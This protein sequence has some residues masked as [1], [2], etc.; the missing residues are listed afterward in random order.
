MCTCTIFTALKLWICCI[1][2]ICR[3]C[4]K[5]HIICLFCMFT[6]FVS[7]CW[8]LIANSS[9]CAQERVLLF[10]CKFILIYFN[11]FLKVFMFSTSHKNWKMYNW[12]KITTLVEV[13]YHDDELVKYAHSNNVTVSYI[14]IIFNFTTFFFVYRCWVYQKVCPTFLLLRCYWY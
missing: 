2:K 10:C 14:G 7:N 5:M 3:C 8:I 4:D 9:F 6:Y 12:S 13:G 1:I 11:W